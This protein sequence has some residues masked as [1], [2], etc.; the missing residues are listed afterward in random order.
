MIGWVAGIVRAGLTVGQTTVVISI[1]VLLAASR[2]VVPVLG[3]LIASAR[4][5]GPVDKLREWLV[6]NN[7]LIIAVLLLV[8]G[9]FHDPKRPR[10][11]L[12]GNL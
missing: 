1:F 9:R 6:D 12:V 8:I 10:R 2:V 11:F 7:A 5:A 3:Y 4:L